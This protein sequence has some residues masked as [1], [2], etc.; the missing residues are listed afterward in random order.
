MNKQEEE[1]I[2][3]YQLA[4]DQEK[5]K[6]TQLAN[7]ATSIF[8]S[9]KDT[10][11]VEVQLDLKEI[12]DKIYHLLRSDVI[13]TDEKGNLKYEQVKDRRLR[14]LSEYGVQLMMNVIQSY[15]IGVKSAAWTG[16]AAWAPCA[17]CR[18]FAIIG[19][20]SAGRSYL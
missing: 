16:G 8:E 9:N 3:K 10:T 11:L 2:R 20:G 14:V 7:A 1:M 4:L 5:A 13:V 12:I 18:R 19:S 17:R 15:L 6:T